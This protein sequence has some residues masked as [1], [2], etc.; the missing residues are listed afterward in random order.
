MQVITTCDYPSLLCGGHG[1]R[2]VI[3]KKPFACW[4]LSS[5]EIKSEEIF[6]LMTTSF[7]EGVGR[8]RARLEG[9]PRGVVH[10]SGSRG[11]DFAVSRGPG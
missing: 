7:G 5:K 1:L 9:P 3:L 6:G 4:Y 8:V 2:E 10:F 11:V